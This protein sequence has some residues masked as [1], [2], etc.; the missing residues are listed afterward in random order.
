MF[1][2][3][4]VLVGE[5][6]GDTGAI[7]RALDVARQLFAVGKWD[8][9]ERIIIHHAYE[10]HRKL[11]LTPGVYNGAVNAVVHEGV[12]ELVEGQDYQI[13]PLPPNFWEM[14]QLPTPEPKSL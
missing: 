4:Q 7:H 12:N 13:K 3:I 14:H 2:S 10:F 5:G 6:R 1:D 8:G 9:W 11:S